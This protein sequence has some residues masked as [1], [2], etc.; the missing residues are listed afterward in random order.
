MSNG[1]I[2][3]LIFLETLMVG[4][5]AIFIGIGMSIFFSKLVAMILI[6]MTIP[7]FAG[8]VM[9]NVSVSGILITVAIFMTFFCV[10]GLSGLQ[11]INRFQLAEL[12]KASKTSERRTRGSWVVLVISAA[13]IGFG[14]YLAASSE[15]ANVINSTLVILALV[16]AGTFLF[17]AGGLPKVLSI[18]KS[19]KRKYYKAGNLVA[20]SGFA[21]RMRSIGAVMA[22]IA[23]LSA[24]ATTAIATGF[25]LYTNTEKN[26]YEQTGYDLFFYGSQDKVLDNVRR[27]LEESGA[28]ITDELTVQRYV[29]D[30]DIE[31]FEAEGSTYF[32]QDDVSMRVYSQ[33]QYNM[34]LNA[35]KADLP[36]VEIENENEAVYASPYLSDGLQQAMTG[37][38]FFIGD[39][40][41]KVTQTQKCAFTGFGAWHILVLSDNRFDA[42]SVSG[43]IK[44]SYSPGDLLD[45]A[46][47]I[48][49]TKSMSSDI[50]KKLDAIL[51]GNVSGYRLAYIHYSESLRI[52]GLVRFIGFFMGAVVILMTASLLYF[53]QIMA[54]E[55]EKH[56]YV[57]LKKIGM[58]EKT[59][60]S[61]I[62]K[63]LLPV[64]LVPLLVGIAHSIF[65]M[66]SADTLV[67]SNMITGGN[68]YLTVL[69]FSSVMYLT[70]A[71]VYGV[72]YL[73]T[74][75]QYIRTI[76]G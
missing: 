2:G 38:E 50:N 22:T 66:K 60:N 68:S 6:K 36:Q 37:K 57:A 73:I 42:L 9:F 23:V 55:E 74:K 75:S 45:K 61:V 16:I 29:T 59:Q 8:R 41:I 58:D 43:N 40:K 12:F 72:F 69:G 62:S 70:Y 39:T 33:S 1:K 76:K 31:A 13:L 30:P 27:T 3:K 56:M 44:D 71:V 34:L 63:R 67:F 35:S 53:K 49:H 5:A 14:Y 17:F 48:N 15:A 19:N 7:E 28:K 21:H 4:G 51:S 52:F 46:T 18:I 10:L 64:F 25:T 32:G 20:I 54:A 47:V 11:V 65:A 24:V 26:A